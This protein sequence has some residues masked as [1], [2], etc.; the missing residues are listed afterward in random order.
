MVGLRCVAA[1][2]AGSP[3][4]RRVWCAGKSGA[5]VLYTVLVGGGEAQREQ[6]WLGDAAAAAGVGGPESLCTSFA[7]AVT[8]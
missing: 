3:A 5:G 2:R 8:L 7:N 6:P 1:E 4:Q